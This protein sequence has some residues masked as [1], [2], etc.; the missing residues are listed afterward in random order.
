[1]TSVLESRPA[2]RQASGA[3]WLAVLLLGWREG[4]RMVLSPVPVGPL[5]DP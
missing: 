5:G 2:Q 4:R 3:T 1:M